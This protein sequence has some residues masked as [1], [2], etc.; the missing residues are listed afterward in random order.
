MEWWGMR[1]GRASLGRR[2]C[3]AGQC[4]QIFGGMSFETSTHE[5]GS[6]YLLQADGP[7]LCPRSMQRLQD[8]LSCYDAERRDAVNASWINTSSDP[9]PPVTDAVTSPK[10]EGRLNAQKP[11]CCMSPRE[12]LWSCYPCAISTPMML[13]E[14]IELHPASSVQRAHHNPP[15]AGPGVDFDFSRTPSSIPSR[16]AP[17]PRA[18][19]PPRPAQCI[20][21]VGKSRPPL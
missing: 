7:D 9:V 17:P 12:L 3:A 10:P 18:P 13:M 4:C 8:M 16:A 15:S 11:A 6:R 21:D 1:G 20:L 2:R 5:P 14:S 19:H